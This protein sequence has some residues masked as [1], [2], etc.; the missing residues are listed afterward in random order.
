MAEEI[1]MTFSDE[2]G[3]VALIPGV[4]GIYTIKLDGKILFSKDKS[5]GFPE[6]KEIKQMI[7]DQIAPEKSLG[8]SDR[9]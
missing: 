5:G 9:R 8:H 1:L 7:R 6:I 2:L 4:G 3:E